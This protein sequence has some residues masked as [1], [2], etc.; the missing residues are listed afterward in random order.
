M[1]NL[2]IK[3]TSN[4]HYV[5]PGYIEVSLKEIH[6]KGMISP[7]VWILLYKLS[8]TNKY[9][10]SRRQNTFSAFLPYQKTAKCKFYLFFI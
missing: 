5:E 4:T 8:E 6:L 1:Q 10:E 9:R 3:N 2:Y 7:V